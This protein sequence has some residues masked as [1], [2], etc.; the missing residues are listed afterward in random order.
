MA[1]ILG[2]ISIP[3]P[4]ASGLTFPLVSDFGY[5]TARP[6]PIVEH[7][8]GELSALATQ[9]Y[10]VGI[11][12]RTFQFK[13]AKLN[14]ANR[15]ALLAFFESMQ[16]SFQSFT[17]NAPQAD[18]TTVAY[19]VIFETAPLSVTE[20]TNACQVGFNFLE[21]FDPAT[22]PVYTVAATCLRFPSTALATAL[23]D[24]VQQIVPLVHIRVRDAYDAVLNPDGVPDI[25]LSD[26]RVTV[27]GQLYLPRLMDLGEAGTTTIMSQDISGAADN[28]QFTFGNADRVM[29]AL[30][31]DTDLRYATIDLSLYH[32]NSGILLQLWSGFILTFAT[33]GG[34][35]F[36]VQASDGTYE[37]NMQYPTRVISRTCWKTFN[38]GAA[39]PWATTI[40]HKGDGT[41]CD[42]YFDSV[43]GCQSHGMD[44]FFGGQPAE[45][46][47]VFL[48]DNTTGFLGFQRNRVTATS[49]ISDTIWGQPL[50]EIYCN[51]GGDPGNNMPVNAAMIDVR[52]E[53][54]FFDSLGIV[55][56]GPIGE[57]TGMSVYTNSD[58][59]SYPIAPMTDGNLPQ[60]FKLNSHLQITGFHP[61]MGLREVAG[62]DPCTHLAGNVSVSG[63]TV[64]WVSGDNFSGLGYGSEIFITGAG[65][66]IVG[67]VSDNTHMTLVP[68]PSGGFSLTDLWTAW[69]TLGVSVLVSQF[70]SSSHGYGTLTNVAWY[71]DPD[72]L[73]LGQ[74]TPQTWGPQRAA[75]TA[76]VELRY[77]N[78]NATNANPSGFQPTAPESHAMTVPISQGLAGWTWDPTGATRTLTPGLTNPFWIAINSLLRCLGLFNSDSTTQLD[79]FV[80]SSLI[81]GDG[82]GTAE[83][84]DLTVPVV[85]GTGSETQF[86]FQGSIGGD[87]TQKPFRDQLT[88][89]LNCGLGFFTWEFGRLKLGIRENSGAV[90]AYTRG[91][92]I[93]QSLTLSPIESTFEHLIIDFADR[94]YAFQANTADY[95]DKSHAAYYGRAS[96]R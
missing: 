42:Y 6:F 51:D 32:V 61:L 66:V 5:S 83:I 40:G 69:E 80:L 4:T 59:F 79:Q 75:G 47:G 11:G 17:Y 25:Y 22:A 33:S 24:Q 26:R 46:Q 35:T 56:A 44:D 12:A 65:W 41:S 77:Q 36:T 29:T 95:Q 16:G 68:K 63:T 86:Q 54:D 93:F 72:S 74:G 23:L 30:S 49:I 64:T 53:G 76:F 78:R 38:D 10:Q 62:N 94:A 82:S 21:I 85:V 19:N 9:R 7:H 70:T 96:S 14:Y 34:P 88:Q 39:C 31:N 45:P 43:N 57:F 1:D 8:F 18:Q 52:D 87:G 92:I 3:T 55:G 60:G 71:C 90:D 84:A 2:R 20:L 48:K 73:S 37:I 81:V 50:Q 91:N 15:T 89:I 27:A 28:V 67:V 13:R 58:G